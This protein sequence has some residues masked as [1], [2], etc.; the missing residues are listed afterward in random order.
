ML[1]LAQDTVQETKD[2]PDTDGSDSDGYE[3]PTKPN[4]Y[5]STIRMIRNREV[6]PDLLFHR[7]KGVKDIEDL[8][9]VAWWG[10]L[11]ILP[12]YDAW[13]TYLEQLGWTVPDWLDERAKTTRLQPIMFGHL[14]LMMNAIKTLYLFW[15]QVRRNS[16][17]DPLHLANDQLGLWSAVIKMMLAGYSNYQI[18]VGLYQAAK[19][20]NGKY[21]RLYKKFQ[22]KMW[23]MDPETSITAFNE[24]RT[25]HLIIGEFA[26]L[27]GCVP[28]IYRVPRS[29]TA[30]KL[31]GEDEVAKPNKPN[32]MG[33]NGE[34]ND[35]SNKDGPSK[36]MNDS[37]DGSD[38]N[39]LFYSNM[40]NNN[41]NLPNPNSFGYNSNNN[42]NNNNNYQQQPPPTFDP[43]Y[44]VPNFSNKNPNFRNH[45]NYSNY[46]NYNNHNNYNNG[47]G[48]SSF[49]NPITDED[50]ERRLFAGKDRY[51]MPA[52][53]SPSG[54]HY[55]TIQQAPA[56]TTVSTKKLWAPKLRYFAILYKLPR[57]KF[58]PPNYL[59]YL[60]QTVT[61]YCAKFNAETY[62]REDKCGNHHLCEFCA[63]RDHG[64]NSCPY[65]PNVAFRKPS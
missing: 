9:T 48:R 5:L 23:A 31:E 41:N 40:Q 56:P 49:S 25:D 29:S 58:A 17:N 26:N 27:Q 57:E 45:N 50:Y 39:Q 15:A 55:P 20:W 61:N 51:T 28:D 59:H 11:R 32:F 30:H 22:R 34:N 33:I 42:N 19:G 24:L 2:D 37:Q 43:T 21:N 18:A 16:Y 1:L 3:T 12:N 38:P 63:S 36:D 10:G 64:G 7:L 35:N 52:F 44:N 47:Y 53:P 62:C 60:G 4:G 54:R 8:L 46:S 13:I 65:R 14:G 6:L